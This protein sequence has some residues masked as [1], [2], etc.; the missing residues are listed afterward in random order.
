MQPDN[1]FPWRV[2][3]MNHDHTI[4]DILYYRTRD[5]AE[6]HHCARRAPRV[7]TQMRATDTWHTVTGTVCPDQPERT[8]Q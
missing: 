2:V 6:E 5:E 7:E 8:D 4:T 1:T 3:V